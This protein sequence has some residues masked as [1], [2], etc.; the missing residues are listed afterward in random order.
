MEIF[1]E[2]TEGVLLQRFTAR[3]LYQVLT[4]TFKVSLLLAHCLDLLFSVARILGGVYMIFPPEG[5]FRIKAASLTC[6]TRINHIIVTENAALHHLVGPI[7]TLHI[8]GFI[9]LL[10]VCLSEHFTIK[11][12]DFAVHLATL[13][14][15]APNRV[16][17]CDTATFL[18]IVLADKTETIVEGSRWFVVLFAGLPLLDLLNLF[19][20]RV[21]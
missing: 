16:W 14:D 1:D 17:G 18:Q 15:L 6:F 10:E 2:I 3:V 5:V 13:L 11:A 20:D 4:V 12:A 7:H 9:V 8:F 19:L 21:S